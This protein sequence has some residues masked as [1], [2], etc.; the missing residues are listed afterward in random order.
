M[1]KTIVQTYHFKIVGTSRMYEFRRAHF[2]RVVV[3]LH[4]RKTL[5]FEFVKNTRPSEFR[6]RQSLFGQFVVKRTD[7]AQIFRQ[8]FVLRP[9]YQRGFVRSEFA[10][11]FG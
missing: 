8:F 3:H 9:F 5:D 11:I 2:H 10:R 7:F 4:F 1:S 6:Y